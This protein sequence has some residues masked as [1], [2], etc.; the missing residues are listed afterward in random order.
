MIRVNYT[1]SQLNLI[2]L[3]EYKI[4]KIIKIKKTINININTRF[5]PIMSL[6]NNNFNQLYSNNAS[7]ISKYNSIPSSGYKGKLENK[8]Y[9][10]TENI[11]S[12]NAQVGK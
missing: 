5:G 8:P 11:Q 4:N 1:F 12:L 9:N 2:N 10:S 3:N 6:N 7:Y